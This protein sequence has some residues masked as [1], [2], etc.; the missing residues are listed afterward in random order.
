M[1]EYIFKHQSESGVEIRVEA[2]SFEAAYYK[3]VVITKHS[4]DYKCINV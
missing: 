4:A 1:K 3:L 2:F